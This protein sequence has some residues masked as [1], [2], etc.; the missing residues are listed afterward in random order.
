LEQA[1]EDARVKRKVEQPESAPAKKE[2]D[3]REENPTDEDNLV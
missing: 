3:P 2:E 1:A